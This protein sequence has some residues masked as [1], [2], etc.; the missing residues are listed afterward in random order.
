[1]QFAHI[2]SKNNNVRSI[3]KSGSKHHENVTRDAN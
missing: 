1:M 2:A 3:I